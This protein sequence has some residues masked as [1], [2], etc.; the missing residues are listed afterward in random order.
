MKNRL[1]DILFINIAVAFALCSCSGSDDVSEEEMGVLKA[2]RFMTQSIN[3]TMLSSSSP[4]TYR[5]LTYNYNTRYF[6]NI[7]TG[8]YFGYPGELMI[9]TVLDDYGYSKT[10]ERDERGILD[11][12]SGNRW[13]VCISPG[14]KNNSDGSID[15]NLSSPTDRIY[16]SIKS[17]AVGQFKI[18][19]LPALTDHR[20]RLRFNISIDPSMT[21]KISSIEVSNFELIGIGAK[22]EPVH[23]Y[24]AQRQIATPKSK[25]SV[26]L[27][28]TTPEDAPFTAYT[29]SEPVY[30]ASAIYAPK[31]I[32]L[33]KIGVSEANSNYILSSDYLQASF[34]LSQNG[35]H[36]T[37]VSFVLNKDFP[38]LEPLHEYKFNFSVKSSYIDLTLDIYSYEGKIWHDV[39]ITDNKAIGD[40]D[41][42]GTHQGTWAVGSWEYHELNDN[43][44]I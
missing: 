28:S 38:E 21:E 35:G 42:V 4:L 10:F 13:I 39:D 32:A 34:M 17:D 23:L 20:S 44:D 9:P 14:K 5:I 8:T 18:Y 37:K 26:V 12:V 7:N 41:E 2:P 30:I 25:R 6:D 1:L 27:D 11:G 16:Y 19:E 22:D 3:E 43:L 29:N 36:S 15:F 24:P 33:K 31:S 40:I